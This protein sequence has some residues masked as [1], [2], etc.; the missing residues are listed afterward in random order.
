MIRRNLLKQGPV[1]AAGA[2]LAACGGGNAAAPGR[3]NFLLVHGAWHAAAHWTPLAKALTAMGHSVFSIDL[4]G[5]GLNARYP[6]SYLTNDFAKLET[7]ISPSKDVHLSDYR[8]AIVAQVNR[9]ADFGKVTLVGHSFGG[10]SITLAGEAV[11]EKI[12]RLVYLTAFVPSRFKSLSE[13]GALPENASTLAS[14]IYVGDSSAIGAVRI[15][16]RNGD[17]VYV[18]KAR[19][20]FYGDV[21]TQDFIGFASYLNPDLPQ[22][23]V[24]DDARGTA[25][26]WGRIPRTFIRCTQDRALPIELQD[27]MISEADAMTPSNQFEV[28]TMAASHSPF[29][30]MPEVLA[31]ILNGLS[32]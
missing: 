31:D 23:A 9:L 18:E 26:R 3:K 13:F 30:S 6:L 16:P 29:A 22:A 12:A 5:S 20:A 10:L 25:S 28:K 17:P 14:T 15:N 11:P 4:P 7:E 19:A 1:F 2:A 27:R 32:Y 21:S 8:D 24:T